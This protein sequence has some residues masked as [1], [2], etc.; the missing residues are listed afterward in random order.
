MRNAV[1]KGIY[2]K[3]KDGAYVQKSDM[4]ASERAVFDEKVKAGAEAYYDVNKVDVYIRLLDRITNTPT[5]VYVLYSEASQ[6]QLNNSEKFETLKDYGI[7]VSKLYRL[8]NEL[9][10][11]YEVVGDDLN[12]V[13]PLALRNAFISLNLYL[14]TYEVSLNI[15]APQVGVTKFQYAKGSE[16]GSYDVLSIAQGARYTNVDDANLHQ[17]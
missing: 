4:S 8:T 16:A 12:I 2:F 15:L 13:Q 9:T 6:S 11:T 1:N 14:W 5:D 3:D 7:N 10:G 17:R